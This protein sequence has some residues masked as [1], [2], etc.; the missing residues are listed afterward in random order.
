MLQQIIKQY[1]TWEPLVATKNIIYHGL[2]REKRKNFGSLNPDKT[3]YVIRSIDD[4]SPFY[5]GAIHNLLANYFYVLSHLQYAQVN[6]WI[7]IVDQ[8]NYPVYNSLSRP[9]NGTYNP[10]EYFWKQPTD[11]PLDEVYQS[12]N[13]VL[14]KQSW[15]GQWDM[16]YDVQKYLDPQIVSQ[17]HFLSNAVPLN[18]AMQQSINETRRSRFPSNGR[19]LGVSFRYGGH[20]KSSPHHG[21]G[22]PMQ[23]EVEDLIEL[24]QRRMEEWDMQYLFLA[25][26]ESRAVELF[27]QRF[28]SQLIVLERNRISSQCHYEKNKNP[29]YIEEN[30]FRTTQDYLTE[31]ELLATCDGLLGSITSGLR[32]ALV[33]NGC[34]YQNVEIID[35]GLFSDNRRRKKEGTM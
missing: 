15:F 25:S 20:A 29:L 13:V 18:D 11:I 2:T 5:I 16:G 7:S 35:C 6:G 30:I 9:V 3:F 1:Q 22:H 32:Y 31:M 10:W 12:K 34:K 28:G 17:F 14:S 19:I 33:K 27:Q 26:D 8:L 4:K 21:P 24:S 23:P